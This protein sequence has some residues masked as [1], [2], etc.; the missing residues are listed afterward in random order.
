MNGIRTFYSP[1]EIP[2]FHTK[3]WDTTHERMARGMD[4]LKFHPDLSCLTQRPAGALRP[5]S[6]PLDTPRRTPMIVRQS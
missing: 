5:S 2:R 4:S 1:K 3:K 6:N